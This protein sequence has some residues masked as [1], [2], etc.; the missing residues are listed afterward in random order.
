MSSADRRNGNVANDW[1]DVGRQRRRPLI[2]MLGVA[3]V[4]FIRGDVGL[5]HGF[6][7]DTCDSCR[8]R[9]CERV[10]GLALALFKRVDAFLDGD[11]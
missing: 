10:S 1:V 2:A 7:S 11:P 5:G 6:E 4:T 8:L 9:G 3:P